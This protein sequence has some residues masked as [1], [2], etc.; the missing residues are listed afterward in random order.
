V[1]APGGMGGGGSK[2]GQDRTFCGR[3]WVWSGIGGSDGTDFASAKADAWFAGIQWVVGSGFWFALPAA[4]ASP[5]RSGD[6]GIS[7]LRGRLGWDRNM[8]RGRCRR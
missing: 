8:F 7:R 1:V 6:L 4:P 2:E 5:S 3:A